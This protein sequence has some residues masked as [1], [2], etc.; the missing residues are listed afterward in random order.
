MPG[1][2]ERVGLRL[3]H[4]VVDLRGEGVPGRPAHRR[5]GHRDLVGGHGDRFGPAE[6]RR[7]CPATPD[8]HDRREPAEPVPV[9]RRAL[10]SGSR[11]FS[12]MT[13]KQP[14]PYERRARK[15]YRSQSCLHGARW[16]GGQAAEGAAR[17][18]PGKLQGRPR[19]RTLY[20]PPISGVNVCVAC[21]GRVNGSVPFSQYSAWNF[22]LASRRGRTGHA[23]RLGV[24]GGARH[25]RRVTVWPS[26]P[27]PSGEPS[28]HAGSDHP[29]RRGTAGSGD[30]RPYPGRRPGGRRFPPDRLPGHQQQTPGQRGDAGRVLEVIAE[31]G[32]TPTGWPRRWPAGRC[33]R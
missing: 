2:D 3:D 7:R 10:S 17:R 28:H 1:R 19:T 21:R 8:G 25:R 26:I 13:W 16:T 4:V 6:V 18:V 31:L 30:R 27:T 29:L 9:R 12:L 15:C 24:A 22:L 20:T 32:C 5:R 11:R 23:A 33:V 14:F